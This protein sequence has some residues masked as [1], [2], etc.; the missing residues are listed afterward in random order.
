M[1]EDLSPEA[2]EDPEKRLH[3]LIERR[4]RL[5]TLMK[6]AIM[7][8]P[9]PPNRQFRVDQLTGQLCGAVDTFVAL[10]S[11]E[12][13]SSPTSRTPH[14]RAKALRTFSV[15]LAAAK[16]A[17]HSLDA[18]ALLNLH[19]V[20]HQMGL[21][22]DLHEDDFGYVATEKWQGLEIAARKAAVQFEAQGAQRGR[23]EDRATRLLAEGLTAVYKNATR[24]D[25]TRTYT[26]KGS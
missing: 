14:Q 25:P 17:W 10:T 21:D 4:A 6:A 12:V 3:A 5:S 1:S 2:P 23:Q 20:S 15:A 11:D 18:E 9:V 13:Q 7:E 26:T 16:K 24:K 8:L 22:W 19:D